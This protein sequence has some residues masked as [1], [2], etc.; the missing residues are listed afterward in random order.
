M[1]QMV[2][3]QV[4]KQ[5]HFQ[6]CHGIPRRP[7]VI[8]I[9]TYEEYILDALDLFAFHYLLKPLDEEKFEGY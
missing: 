6:N 9:T 2:G 8:F 5:L 1:Q 3:I 7:A 4:V